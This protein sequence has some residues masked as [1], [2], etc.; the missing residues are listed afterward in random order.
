LLRPEYVSLQFFTHNSTHKKH[1]HL[2][3]IEKRESGGGPRG[4]AGTAIEYVK[5]LL[6]HVNCEF[7]GLK[8]EEMH[9][10][11]VYCVAEACIIGKKNLLGKGGG[12]HAHVAVLAKGK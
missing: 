10:E 11:F 5:G 4:K 6:D 1:F 8:C 12:T 2:F 3:T 7:S 9:L